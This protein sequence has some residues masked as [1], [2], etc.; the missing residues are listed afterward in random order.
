MRGVFAAQQTWLP[1]VGSGSIAL[2]SA[3]AATAFIS[4]SP[5]KR[6]QG[7]PPISQPTKYEIGLNLRTAKE[8]GIEIPPSLLVQ[9]NEVIEGGTAANPRA[10]GAILNGL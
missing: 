10:M 6:T 9:A 1:D 5:R 4:A 8:L 3:E 2:P 7:P